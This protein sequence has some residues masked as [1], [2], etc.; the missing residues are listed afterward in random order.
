MTV[1][2]AAAH[3]EKQEF[4]DAL[5]MH[6]QDPNERRCVVCD[7]TG[8]FMGSWRKQSTM[9]LIKT[10][11]DQCLQVAPKKPALHGGDH[12]GLTI[13]NSSSQFA[14]RSPGAH[15]QNQEQSM[16]GFMIEEDCD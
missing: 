13:K 6:A 11:V 2:R 3:C 9:P 16:G 5:E 12:Q 15:A 14:Q 10:R 4:V 7:S 1:A 8:T